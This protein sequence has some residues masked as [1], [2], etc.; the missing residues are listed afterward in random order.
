MS[1][2]MRCY[3]QPNNHIFT[4]SLSMFGKLLLFYASHE[5]DVCVCCSIL[6]TGTENKLNNVSMYNNNN[7]ILYV[8]EYLRINGSTKCQMKLLDKCLLVRAKFCEHTQT[9]GRDR[10]ISLIESTSSS[11]MLRII[12][13]FSWYFCSIYLYNIV[14][15]WHFFTVP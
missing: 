13:M 6:K 2:W 14:V 7:N 1:V 10:G 3:Q 11:V 12:Y 5:C 4:H 9:D 15:W 8:C